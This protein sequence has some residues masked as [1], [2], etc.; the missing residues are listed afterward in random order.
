[1]QRLDRYW[2]ASYILDRTNSLLTTMD[3]C[4]KGITY[5]AHQLY[6]NTPNLVCTAGGRSSSVYVFYKEADDLV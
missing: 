2:A 3:T 4:H 5:C 1:M 6:T